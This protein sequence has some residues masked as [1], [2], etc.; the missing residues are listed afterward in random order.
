M[1]WFLLLKSLH[2][3]SAIIAVGAN[4]TYAL[5]SVRAK[6]DP[7]HLGFALRGIKFIDDRVANP[8][9]GVLLA[10]GLI[11][12]F[13][14]Y[15]ITLS[16]ILLGLGAWIVMALVAVIVYSPALSRQIAALEVEGI[17]S[18]RFRAADAR[19]QAVGMFLGVLAVFAVVVMV[20]KPQ[21]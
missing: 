19:A 13:T 8:A 6:S 2:V 15:R 20:F 12:A 10:T 18:P 16:W 21:F 9:Y 14:T 17:S 5:W 11:M 4:A 7:A 1:S 3:L